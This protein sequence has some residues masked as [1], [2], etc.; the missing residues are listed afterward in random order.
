MLAGAGVGVVVLIIAAFI[1]GRAT[2]PDGA[3]A[4]DATGTTITTVAENGGTTTTAASGD[5]SETSTTVAIGG[6]P[7]A[8]L[9][10][11]VGTGPQYGTEADRD[12]LIE[13][14]VNAGV[15]GG[16][17]E[18]VLA[19][20]DHVCHMLEQLEAQ[21]RSPAYAVRVVWNESLLELPS[22]DLAAFAAVFNSAPYY[23]CPDSVEYGER[24]AYW[25][26]F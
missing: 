21:R 12:A 1:I 18:S 3:A 17:R 16:T 2:A 11:Y 14:L 5:G 8:A 4:D 15:G 6:D 22:E 23:L 19:T 9:P 20:A 10:V 26:G 24:V 13:G 25:L 7:A